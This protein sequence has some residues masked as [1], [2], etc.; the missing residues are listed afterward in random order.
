MAAVRVP[1]VEARGSDLTLTAP[2]GGR[3]LVQGVDIAAAVAALN[4][5][6]AALE[7]QNA[8]LRAEVAVLRAGQ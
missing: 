2:P 7:A 4:A 1:E 6:V 3:V 8:Q 5:Q